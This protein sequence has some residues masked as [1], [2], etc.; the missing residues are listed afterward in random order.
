ML[1]PRPERDIIAETRANTAAG[2]I[3]SSG[4]HYLSEHELSLPLVS[5]N[6]RERLHGLYQQH[7]CER[8][9]D[10]EPERVKEM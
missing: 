1:E 3:F 9:G 2:Y 8:E 7:H 4:L 5:N 6:C 10:K